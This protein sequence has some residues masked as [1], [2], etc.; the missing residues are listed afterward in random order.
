MSKKVL[1]ILNLSLIP[2]AKLTSSSPLTSP[3]SVELSTGVQRCSCCFQQR[4]AETLKSLAGHFDLHVKCDSYSVTLEED[5]TSVTSVE[6]VHSDIN[7]DF[8]LT[9]VYPGMW[10]W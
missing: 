10:L 3:F 8:S 1:I 2:A 5:Q 4:E 9:V 6:A 7:N